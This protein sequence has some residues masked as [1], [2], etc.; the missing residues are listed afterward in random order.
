MRH[1]RY[2]SCYPNLAQLVYLASPEYPPLLLSFSCRFSSLSHIGT[3]ASLYALASLL[4]H[5]NKYNFDP[6]A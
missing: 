6:T 5:Y 3:Y 4:R 2:L 1:R